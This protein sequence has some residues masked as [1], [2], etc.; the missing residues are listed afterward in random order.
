MHNAQWQC[1]IQDGLLRR[2]AVFSGWALFPPKEDH[3]CTHCI[4]LG[5][6]FWG[7]V[8]FWRRGNFSPELGT[9]RTPSKCTKIRLCL[10]LSKNLI[11]QTRYFCF[12]PYIFSW[13]FFKLFHSHS[14][15]KLKFDTHSHISLQEVP[16]QLTP[17]LIK[18]I[19]TIQ[20]NKYFTCK[21]YFKNGVI[22]WENTQCVCAESN[23]FCTKRLYIQFNFSGS[24]RWTIKL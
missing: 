4:K 2:V 20:I 21:K 5:L 10:P 19:E 12:L 22:L 11:S 16:G 9:K 15:S 17:A 3:S 14:F 24:R 8:G 23:I 7:N 1:A 6:N 18:V 13:N